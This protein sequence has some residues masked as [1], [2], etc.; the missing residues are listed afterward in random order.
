M[1]PFRIAEVGVPVAFL[2]MWSSGAVMVKIGLE[3]SSVWSFLAVR[4]FGAT[5][6][7]ALICL[8][9]LAIGTASIRFALDR[10]ALL[11]MVVVGLSLHV[12]YQCLF[13]LSLD[14]GLAPGVLAII[15]GLQPLF[16]PVLAGE[17]VGVREGAVLI[18]GFLGLA[19][20]IWGSRSLGGFTA[21]GALFGVMSAIAISWGTI[22][23]SSLD[24]HPVVSALYQSV[25]GCVVFGTVVAITGWQIDPTTGFV[26]ASLWMILVVSVGATLLLFLMLRYG[27][28]GRVG[29]LFYMVPVLA[30]L[31]D[32]LV[33]GTEVSWL[34][35]LGAL[36]VAA[37][38]VAYRRLC[39]P[40]TGDGP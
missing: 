39:R 4:S 14:H 35:A 16:V 5:V 18:C 31:L 24:V 19:V 6:V 30:V 15:L 33:F 8:V 27:V 22:K 7:L 34:T 17:R 40:I 12:G 36:V 38:V 23:Q 1:V 25:V 2:L 11:Q 26:V 37:S 20:C 21:A 32:Y 10:R 28:A 13:F 3:S 29:V 9:A